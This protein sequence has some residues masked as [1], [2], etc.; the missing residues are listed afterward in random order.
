MTASFAR[1]GD[2]FVRRAPAAPGARSLLGRGLGAAPGWM[3]P[4]VMG[5]EAGEISENL[6]E[7]FAGLQEHLL[8]AG[9]VPQGDRDKGQVY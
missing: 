1:R 2:G 3:H 6:L 9:A 7:N 4:E 8:S 5:M